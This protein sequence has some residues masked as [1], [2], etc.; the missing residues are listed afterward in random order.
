MF[1]TF[2]WVFIQQKDGTVVFC[3]G[4]QNHCKDTED[5]CLSQRMQCTSVNGLFYGLIAIRL[6]WHKY[7]YKQEWTNT[8]GN[9]F[10]P[11]FK[12]PSPTEAYFCLLVA[13]QTIVGVK[14]QCLWWTV[15]S[16][17]IISRVHDNLH[18]VR[19]RLYLQLAFVV[20]GHPVSG[21]QHM[22]WSW[23]IAP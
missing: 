18:K 21:S 3:R 10:L 22:P 15:A 1:D 17:R 8:L 16:R 12:Y 13:E 2:F 6:I 11:L 20:L 4:D 9:A 14:Y 7:V 19:E 5:S 23:P